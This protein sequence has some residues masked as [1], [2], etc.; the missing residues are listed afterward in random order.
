MKE[1]IEQRAAYAVEYMGTAAIDIYVVGDRFD[2]GAD[3]LLL[4]TSC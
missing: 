2:A 4:N 1:G 3:E